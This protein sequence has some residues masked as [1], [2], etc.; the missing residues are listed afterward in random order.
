MMKTD[1]MFTRLFCQINFHK[2]SNIKI[3]NVNTFAQFTAF[4]DKLPEKGPTVCFFFIGKKK[5][6]GHSWCIYCQLGKRV[7]TSAF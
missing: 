1:F 3:E 7:P 2:M 6:N 5:E 4:V